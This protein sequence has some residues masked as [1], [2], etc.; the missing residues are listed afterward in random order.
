MNTGRNSLQI[1]ID[2]PAGAG[3]STV[4]RL[5]ARKMG[6]NYLD[7]GAMYRAIA[8]KVLLEGIPLA[9]EEQI[10]K[11][12]QETSLQ[13]DFEDNNS[14]YCDGKN[15]TAEIRTQE[16]TKA[17]SIIAA[18]PGVRKYLVQEQR[19]IAAEGNIVMDGRDIG[20]YVLPDAPVKIFLTASLEERARRRVLELE[21]KQ[22]S[23]SLK[24]ILNDMEQRD[25]YDSE[26]Q[27]NP[28]KPAEDALVLDTTGLSKEQVAEKIVQVAREVQSD[29]L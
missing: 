12:V 28:L 10:V 4:A 27:T 1:S 18:Y 24:G 20:T 29:V 7:T 14:I 15:V 21:Q 16:V 9:Q 5:V 17:V 3:K 2:G 8:Y 26:R 23:I 13:F 6:L 19:K 11:M 22:N 25:R